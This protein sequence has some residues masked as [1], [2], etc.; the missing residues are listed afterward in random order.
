M[1]DG[2]SR[3]SGEL[4]AC[5]VHVAPGLGNALGSLYNAK[6]TGTPMLLPAGQQEQGHGL[7]EPLMYDS[8]VPMAA[9]L[10]KW[11]TE[12]TR[13]EDLPRSMLRAAKVATTAPTG[14]VFI[15]LPGDILNE[16]AGIELGRATRVDTAMR[17]TGEALAAASLASLLLFLGLDVGE[18]EDAHAAKLLGGGDGRVRA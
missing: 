8:L 7:M 6:F 4:V 2:Y 14:P 13:V 15:S 9:P 17:P 11:A 10:V 18:A 1:A 3:A 5:N 12:V 16:E